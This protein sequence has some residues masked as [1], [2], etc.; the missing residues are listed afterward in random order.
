MGT[1]DL[2]TCALKSRKFTTMTVRKTAAMTRPSAPRCLSSPPP[3]HP[4]RLARAPSPNAPA[5]LGQLGRVTAARTVSGWGQSPRRRTQAA[6]GQLHTRPSTC[7]P[8]RRPALVPAHACG[9]CAQVLK[10]H[11]PFFQR[12]KHGTPKSGGWTPRRTQWAD[13]PAQAT[14]PR[15]RV[16]HPEGLPAPDPLSAQNARCSRDQVATSCLRAE[17]TRRELCLS[18]EPGIPGHQP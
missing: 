15:Q 4:R 16:A 12:S 17:D 9:M 13:K 11:L 7:A 2:I 1:R 5:R 14:P 3:Q 6:G 18:P 8:D 10:A